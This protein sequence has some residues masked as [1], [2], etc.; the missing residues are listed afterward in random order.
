MSETTG[1]SVFESAHPVWQ[2]G[3]QHENIDVW[4]SVQECQDYHQAKDGDGW[5]EQCGQPFFFGIFQ[6]VNEFCTHSSH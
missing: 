5:V 2:E 6:K 3:E 4:L 1:V